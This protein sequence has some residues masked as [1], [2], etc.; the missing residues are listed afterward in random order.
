ML[1]YFQIRF[2][3][4]YIINCLLLLLNFMA[5]GISYSHIGGMFVLL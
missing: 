4:F 1:I 5:V 3:F 2:L